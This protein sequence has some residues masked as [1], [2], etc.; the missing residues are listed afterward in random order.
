VVRFLTK[1]TDFYVTLQFEDLEDKQA[2][3][4][5][6]EQVLDVVDKFPV[7]ETPGPQPGYVG[8]TFKA[9]EAELR[10]WFTQIDAK[11]AL[12]NGS[13]GEELFDVLQAK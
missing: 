6:I 10:L 9:P 1:E 11:A 2:L 8:I 12:E 13:R 7:E 5:L 4:G 3:G